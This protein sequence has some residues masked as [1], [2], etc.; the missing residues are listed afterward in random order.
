MTRRIKISVGG[1][2][3]YLYFYSGTWRCSHSDGSTASFGEV[4][5]AD[6]EMAFRF[7]LEDAPSD[8]DRLALVKSRLKSNSDA[9][10]FYG[11]SRWNKS[12]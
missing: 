7:M 5:C 10:F 11:G 12:A 3:F 8:F 6:D 4:L 9:E 2:V 1:D